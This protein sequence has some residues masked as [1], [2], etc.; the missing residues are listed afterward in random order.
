MAF[1]I[2]EDVR[3][4]VSTGGG[5]RTV[6]AHLT[7]HGRVHGVGYRAATRVQALELGLRGWVGDGGDGSI[8]AV[9]EG[10]DQKVEALVVWCR[11]GPPQ[12]VVQ[13]VDVLWT[14]PEHSFQTF[15]ISRSIRQ[16][17]RLETDMRAVITT[18]DPPN[19]RHVQARIQNMSAT[20]Y[21]VLT[22]GQYRMGDLVHLSFK[23]PSGRTFKR[24]N[25][26]VVRV[27]PLVTVDGAVELGAEFIDPPQ[28]LVSEIN[29]AVNLLW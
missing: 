1:D 17:A 22:L 13:S 19:E 9:V 2:R 15:S 27:K 11:E 5:P 7:V 10:P 26:R 16:A 6:R 21:C 20:G 29:K 24:I 25:S 23:A 14:W 8:Q 18:G 28:F 12:A 3:I 4:G